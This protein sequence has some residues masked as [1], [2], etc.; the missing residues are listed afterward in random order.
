MTRLVEAIHGAKLRGSLCQPCCAARQQGLL[1]LVA[2]Y[3]QPA[4][5]EEITHSVF[6]ILAKKSRLLTFLRA[7]FA[8]RGH[9][10]M[11]RNE[12]RR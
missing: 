7:V 12:R 10:L 3:W 6:V 1:G 9:Y 4:S 5:A 2:S 8:F 11:R